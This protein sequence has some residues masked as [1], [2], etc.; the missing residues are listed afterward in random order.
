MSHLLSLALRSAW[1]RR[2]TLGLT[3]LAIALSV[4]LLLGVERLRHDAREA[5]DQSVSGT[6]LIVGARTSPVQ[7]VLYAVFRM[8]EATSNFRWQSYLELAARPEVAWSI[9]L[10]LG[11]SHQGFPVLGTTPAYFEHF[12]YGG[13]RTLELADG[14]PF[15]EVFETVL[16]ADVARRLGYRV[17]ERIVLSHGMSEV[18]LAQHG[19]KPFTVVGVL[20]PTGTPVDRT[21]HISL[22]AMQAIHLD[23]QGGAPMPGVSIPAEYVRKFDLTPKHITAALVGLKSRAAVFRVQRSVNDYPGEALVAVLPGVALDELWRIVGVAEKTL[24]AVSA[25][26]TAV[27][28]TGLVAVILAGLNE[29]RRELAILRSVGARPADIFLLLSAEGVFVTLIGAL[30]GIVLLAILSAAAAPLV[31]ARLGFHLQPTLVSGAELQWLALVVA[32]GVLASVVPGYRAYR[33]SL[34][35]GLS[36]RI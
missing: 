7:L 29:R 23:W 27:G 33:L 35:D 18:A 25:M 34:A 13:S 6:D 31:Q 32:I 28:L 1:N 36:P 4:M 10:S 19:D 12:R 15:A 16:G 24:L 30:C 8:G 5:F 9:P 2:Y 17:G 11:D 14:K 3:M 20:R 22:A 21:L 26:V